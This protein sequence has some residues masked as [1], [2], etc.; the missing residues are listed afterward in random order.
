MPNKL[1]L[2]HSE[3]K[4]DLFKVQ[5]SLEARRKRYVAYYGNCSVISHP[6]G[7]YEFRVPYQGE[8]DSLF[9]RKV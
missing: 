1:M 2:L 4:Q 5:D 8:T 3:T 7:I 9:V 6:D